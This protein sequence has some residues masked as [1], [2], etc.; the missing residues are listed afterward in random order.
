MKKQLLVFFVCIALVIA[1]SAL[2]VFGSPQWSKHI[3]VFQAYYLHKGTDHPFAMKGTLSIVNPPANYTGVW[4]TWYSNGVLATEIT[5]RNG[6][7][8]GK[9]RYYNDDGTFFSEFNA[10]NGKWG[11]L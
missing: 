7:E 9:M 1:V 2:F 5:Y 3:Y 6:V 10:V 11:H 4:R 8:H